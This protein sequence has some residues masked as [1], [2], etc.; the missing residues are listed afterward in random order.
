MFVKMF[1][2]NSN[3]I[4]FNLPETILQEIHDIPLATNLDLKDMLV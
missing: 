3:G 2:L 1:I 4:S